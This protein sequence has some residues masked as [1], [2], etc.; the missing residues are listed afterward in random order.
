MWK[1]NWKSANKSGNLTTSIDGL[2]EPYKQA[3][4]VLHSGEGELVQ[5]VH[6]QACAA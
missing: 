5:F 6:W 1:C 3:R 4:Y 2:A